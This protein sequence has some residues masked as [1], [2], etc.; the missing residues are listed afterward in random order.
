MQSSIFV[1][2][3]VLFISGSTEGPFDDRQVI[4]RSL[5]PMRPADLIDSALHLS[6]ITRNNPI[7]TPFPGSS[8]CQVTVYPTMTPENCNIWLLRTAAVSKFSAMSSPPFV[9][10]VLH[11]REEIESQETSFWRYRSTWQMPFV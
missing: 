11:T 8:D 3:G 4:S 5:Y 2:F 1:A 6:D 10:T 9:F 7:L